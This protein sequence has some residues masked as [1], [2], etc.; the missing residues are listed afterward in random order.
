MSD[1]V[2]LSQELLLAVKMGRPYGAYVEQLAL[3]DEKHLAPAL[4]TDAER[5]A[6]WINVYNAFT[7]L[8][9]HEQ[10]ELYR[11]RHRFYA[12]RLIRIAGRWLS[13]SEVEHG[14]LR[15]SR[16]SLS[17]GYFNH[18]PVSEFEKKHR[19]NQRDARIHFALNCGAA[20]CPPVRF[21]QSARVE[22]QLDIAAE[23]YLGEMAEYRE[24]NNEVG[25]PK[26][27]LWFRGDFGGRR[28][29]WE[30]LR[31]YGVIPAQARPRFRYFSYDWRM[32]LNQFR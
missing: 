31:R 12:S 4:P 20:S 13:L 21:Y 26:L 10:P 3:A 29:I 28:G 16:H 19:V 1:F 17:F 11:N 2:V 18:W 9:L 27:F 8:L 6:F 5:K 15:R 30:L 24:G 7:Q 22:E 25:L 14:I 23:S 32:Q